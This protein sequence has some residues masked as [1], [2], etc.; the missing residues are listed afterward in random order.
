[1]QETIFNEKQSRFG[2][3]LTN[4]NTKSESRKQCIVGAILLKNNF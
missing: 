4:W 3:F 1:M 2:K